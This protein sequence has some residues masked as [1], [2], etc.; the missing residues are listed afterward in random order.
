MME[1]GLLFRSQGD[2][3]RW[4]EKNHD[5][6]EGVWLRIHK[7]GFGSDV[8]RGTEVLDPLLSHGWITGPVRKGT[9]EYVLWWVCPR[10]KNSLWSKV[11]VS[12]A[13]RLISEGKMKPSGLKE[14]EEAK[15][16][17]RWDAAYPPQRDAVLPAD[18][19]RMVDTNRK[20]QEFLKELNRSSVYAIIF[21]LHN[22]KDSKRRQEKMVKIVKMLEDGKTFH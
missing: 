6:S 5:K 9:N 11:N 2:L 8:L 19:L 20:A 21:R 13:E 14:V 7:K 12:H 18:F 16:D 4:L 17:G 15:K 10:R 1:A 22:T 3:G